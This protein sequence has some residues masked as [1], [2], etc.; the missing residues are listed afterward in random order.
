MT[1]YLF[2][3]SSEYIWCTYNVH[4]W[5]KNMSENDAGVCLPPNWPLTMPLLLEAQEYKPEEVPWNWLS[6]RAYEIWHKNPF[7]WQLDASQARLYGQDVV[8]DVGTGCGKTLCFSLPLSP[9][10]IKAEAAGIATVTVCKET[11]SHVGSDKLHCANSI[12]SSHF[13]TCD[14]HDKIFVSSHHQGWFDCQ[15]ILSECPCL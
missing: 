12:N 14:Q 11:L 10:N 7:L 8:V 6:A 15:K 13:V 3:S 4:P 9:L 5:S 1:C 2:E